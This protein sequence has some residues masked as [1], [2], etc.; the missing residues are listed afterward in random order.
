MKKY[1]VLL[2]LLSSCVEHTFLDDYEYNANIS[3]KFADISNVVESECNKSVASV[4]IRTNAEFYSFFQNPA[5]PV[6]GNQLIIIDGDINISSDNLPILIPDGVEIS[7]NL[8]SSI[9]EKS[10]LQLSDTEIETRLEV[11]KIIGENVK[12]SGIELIG[13]YLNSTVGCATNNPTVT[14]PRIG[15]YVLNADN[16]EIF[17]SI[18]SG[19]NGAGIKFE[20]SKN[21]HVHNNLIHKNEAE[22][23]GYGISLK[24]G[25]SALIENNEFRKNRHHVAGTGNQDGLGNF[26]SYEIKNNIIDMT[27]AVSHGIDMHAG[28]NN[29][30]SIYAGG[31]IYIHDNIFKGNASESGCNTQ[32][33]IRI[34]GI[35]TEFCRIE[36]N[37]FLDYPLE[38]KA[39]RQVNNFGNFSSSQNSFGGNPEG[40]YV[41]WSGTE[42]WYRIGTNLS[43]NFTNIKLGK[44][45]NDGQGSILYTTGTEWKLYDFRNSSGIIFKRDE[46]EVVANSQI[47]FEN[48]GLGDFNGDGL[49]DIFRA[50]GQNWFVAYANE[51]TELW[52]W[53]QVGISSS[54]KVKDLG[55]G[56]FNGDGRT[57]ILRANGQNWYV[58]YS[59]QVPNPWEWGIKA[60]STLKINELRLGDFNGDN[61]T[62]I[63]RANG[64]DLYI[65]YS[66]NVSNPWEWNHIAASN[67]SI[68][69]ISV[70]DF[71]GDN[72]DDL[73]IIDNNQIYIAY[74]ANVSNLWE[75]MP[76]MYIT[77]GNTVSEMGINDFNGDGK[78]DIFI[79]K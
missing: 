75:F 50:N 31:S 14:Y 45:R 57:D 1:F 9:E 6:N 60:N 5:E 8:C 68:S 20:N 22:N 73:V 67:L 10:K 35:P 41:S 29:D 19:W 78:D 25:S 4:I 39:I 16:F 7:G 51:G 2:L 64:T 37:S 69:Q 11:F 63:L 28:G 79:I 17:S 38:E 30:P 54:I 18:I 21:G 34:R 77:S 49:T 24:N 72:Y 23:L 32:A 71:N 36:N 47:Q 43:L 65:A 13:P 3:A 26:D 40:F 61:K 12:I 44:F 33:S 59:D 15:I 74:S 27:S 53:T 76:T 48:L 58:A 52:E 70:G 66:D 42:D 55:F 46:P 56:D 62:D